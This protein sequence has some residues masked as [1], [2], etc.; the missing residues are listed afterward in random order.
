LDLIFRIS[1]KGGLPM[2]LDVISRRIETELSG[3]ATPTGS[4]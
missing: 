4:L 3:V 1:I 2:L